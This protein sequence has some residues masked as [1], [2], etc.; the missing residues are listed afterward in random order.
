[1]KGGGCFKIEMA[2]KNGV[3]GIWCNYAVGHLPRVLHCSRAP[4]L[5]SSA[6]TSKTEEAS[7]PGC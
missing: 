2:V 6:E 4:G 3:P 1:M 7:T 5:G